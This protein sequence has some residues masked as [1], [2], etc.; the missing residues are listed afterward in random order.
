[1]VLTFRFSGIGACSSCVVY[2]N[3]LTIFVSSTND[4]CAIMPSAPPSRL[5]S[6]RVI[7][8]EGHAGAATWLQH[9]QD[10]YTGQVSRRGVAIDDGN[11]E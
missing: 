10:L 8:I 2:N 6:H 9:L 3:S 11:G 1:M 4:K 7:T 5:E